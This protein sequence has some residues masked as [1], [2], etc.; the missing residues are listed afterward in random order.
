MI[1]G[2]LCTVIVHV[3]DFKILSTSVA[4]LDFVENLM[5]DKFKKITVKTDIKHDFLGMTFDYSEEGYVSVTQS[6]YINEIIQLAD[7]KRE[8]DNPAIPNLFYVNE[9]SPILKE[10][11]RKKLHT[12]ICK[13]QYLANRTRPDI[14]PV[15]HSCSLLKV[16]FIKYKYCFLMLSL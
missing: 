14:L 1:D 7:V 13:A 16:F 5:R 11:E 9:N 15:A 10:P 2:A 4:A 8:S 3:D 12:L 6:K